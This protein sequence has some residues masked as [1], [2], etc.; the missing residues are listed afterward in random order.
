[1][2]NKITLIVLSIFSF[3]ISRAQT[4]NKFYFDVDGNKTAASN[5]SFSITNENNGYFN[6]NYSNTKKCFSGRILSVDS[7]SFF[8]SKF[9]DTVKW[10]F[11]N[12]K[13]KFIKAYSK[14]GKLNGVTKYFYE[15]GSLWK[16]FNFTENV[17]EENR[18][19][20]FSEDGQRFDI[21]EDNFNDNSSDW[22]L[23]SNEKQTVS[24]V[25][26]TLQL[27]SK[28]KEGTS[29][30]KYL[31]FDKE[32]FIIEAKI[33]LTKNKAEDKGGLIFGFKDWDNYNF[34][35]ISNENVYI[36]TVYEGAVNYSLKEMFS[37]SIEE[38]GFNTLKVISSGADILY[39]INSTVINKSSKISFFG[40]NFGIAAIGK[41]TLNVDEIAFKQIS[42][43]Q[44][45]SGSVSGN[46]QQNNDVK[47]TGTGFFLNTEGYI[48]TNFHVVE[49]GKHFVIDVFDTLSSSYKSYKA[50]VLI[51]DADNDLAILKIDDI[52][53]RP[54][55]YQI[56]YSFPATNSFELGSDA[57]TL[58]FPLALSGMGND[59][60][61]TDGKISAK[62]GYKSAIN[63]FQT[64]IPVQPGNS[65]GPIF[66]HNCE[67]I[68]I[69]NSG[70]A[71]AENVSYGIKNNFLINL[72][73][74]LPEKTNLTQ[75][76][77]LFNLSFEEKIKK[78]KKYI[79]L[80]RV[81]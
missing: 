16:E 30:Y 80:I 7:N 65:G 3:L 66:N 41:F 25:N 55:F 10:F 32:D 79:V 45:G 28:I 53:Y 42:Y 14:E 51:K 5:A 70:I 2:I 35:Y 78:M 67:L 13:E 57:F 74:S 43:S 73:Q 44:M 64:T 29:R 33:E 11:K 24:I 48:A 9:S 26:G 68:G 71:K 47:A 8:N 76:N 19:I 56:E 60:K 37:S 17:L 31:K 77:T 63:S 4:N 69:I 50:S 23:L 81:K 12:G 22:E 21:F 62:T 72:V 36:G 39:T 58:G 49:N 40:N 6:G 52:A 20:E 15:S 18:Y 75:N 61:F 38:K 46:G 27:A 34:F 54:H 1:M 59:V